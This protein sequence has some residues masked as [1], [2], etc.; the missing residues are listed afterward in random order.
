MFSS[1]SILLHEKETDRSKI[2]ESWTESNFCHIG[3]H[4]NQNPTFRISFDEYS[5]RYPRFVWS[6]NELPL[7]GDP[8]SFTM[9]RPIRHPWHTVNKRSVIRTV[10][11]SLAGRLSCD[12]AWSRNRITAIDTFFSSS[13]DIFLQNNSSELSKKMSKIVSLN[14]LKELFKTFYA[15]KLVFVISIVVYFNICTKIICC[16]DVYIYFISKSVTG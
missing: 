4:F 7:H 15:N 8:P 6:K 12:K 2:V 9:R 10:T 3:I 11:V 14:L 16:N 1:R 13:K 5:T